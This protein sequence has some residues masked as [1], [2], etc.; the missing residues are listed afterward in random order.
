MAIGRV[1]K[2]SS[3]KSEGP[4][5]SPETTDFLTDSFGQATNT[6]VSL[7]IKQYK[8]VLAGYT[9]GWGETL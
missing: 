7:F 8:L 9:A 5:S 6:S 3:S 1:G 2:G 4:S